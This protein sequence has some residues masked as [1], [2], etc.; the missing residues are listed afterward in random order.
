MLRVPGSINSKNGKNKT[1]EVVQYGVW[2][3][4]RPVANSMLFNFYI[5]MAAR[6]LRFNASHMKNK[7]RIS[8]NIDLQPITSSDIR[9]SDR[10]F[11]YAN[12]STLQQQHIDWIDLNILHQEHGISDC[13]KITVDLVLAPY[14]INVKKYSYDKAYNIIAQWLDKCSQNK[15]QIDFNARQR[16][17]RALKRAIEEKVKEDSTRISLDR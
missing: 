9:E 13:R 6:L 16:I 3:K 8:V 11:G 4:A 5:E 15:R 7:N 17:D 12:S 10:L 1:V 14:L 2:N